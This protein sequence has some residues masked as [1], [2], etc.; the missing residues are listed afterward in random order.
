MSFYGNKHMEKNA[1]YLQC[2]VAATS[3]MNLGQWN[4][5]GKEEKILRKQLFI[6][7]NTKKNEYIYVQKHK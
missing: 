1:T 7:S 6:K 4:N 2:L 3:H 5:C